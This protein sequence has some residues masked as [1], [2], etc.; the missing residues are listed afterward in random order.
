MPNWERYYADF[1]KSKTPLT[2]T[3]HAEDYRKALQSQ[4][5]QPQSVL[6]GGFASGASI[7]AFENFTR[8]L[9]P[10]A[11]A[12]A[13][14]INTTPIQQARVYSPK[15]HLLRGDLTTPPFKAGSIDLVILDFT[16]NCM[17]PKQTNEF[18]AQAPDIL[19][20]DG[21]I[22]AAL[23][24]TSR[25]SF[26]TKLQFFYMRLAGRPYNFPNVD[27]LID[28][29]SPLTLTYREQTPHPAKKDLST[30]IIILRK[31]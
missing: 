27:S 9:L 4:Q 6:L 25:A 24:N 30:E 16:L 7:L 14:D 2:I 23:N 1:S 8:N 18:F 22:L 31:P 12:F 29:A 15:V 21:A 19:S 3:N 20:P 28:Q 11:Q 10:Q 26:P 13:L 17:T 5:I